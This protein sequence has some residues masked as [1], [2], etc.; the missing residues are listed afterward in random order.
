MK[1]SILVPYERYQQLVEIATERNT[2]SF[3][4][5]LNDV[6]SA[7][8][9]QSSYAKPYSSFSTLND[10]IN[11]NHLNNS[12][13]ILP[14]LSYPNLKV[15]L[16]PPPPPPPQTTTT[17]TTT[18]TLPLTEQR[19]S[20]D[21][22]IACLPK[23]KHSRARK[24]LEILIAHPALD[25]TKHGMLLCN[26]TPIENSHIVD[27]VNS[28]LDVNNSNIKSSVQLPNGYSLFREKLLNNTFRRH[29]DDASTKSHGAFCMKPCQVEKSFQTQEHQQ[30]GLQQL[31]KQLVPP[32]LKRTKNRQK[33][34]NP[35]PLS[36]PSP[37]LPP[38][39]LP[40]SDIVPK[41]LNI[42]KYN[43]KAY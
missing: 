43:W 3:K 33:R 26:D 38:P 35:A 6:P 4:T 29:S 19:L 39:G 13:P 15:K 27:L 1:K 24:L 22:I 20:T 12:S 7:E 30:Q 32:K 16:P 21:V 37:P 17:T 18:R 25:W 42:W 28:A 9:E 8:P 34:R 14:S 41:P 36:P 23:R 31:S 11:D 2:P 5:A 10:Y 40:D